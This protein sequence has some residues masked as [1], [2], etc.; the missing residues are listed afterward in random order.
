MATTYDTKI[1]VER[2]LCPD[3]HTQYLRVERTL[4]P[5]T[6]MRCLSEKYPTLAPV[7]TW[8]PVGSALWGV[9]EP[10]GDGVLLEEGH[11]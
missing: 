2:T 4:R 11:H 9:M 10:L 5:D 3:T 1:T 7:D 8:S 6:H